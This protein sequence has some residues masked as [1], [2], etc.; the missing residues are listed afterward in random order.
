MKRLVLVI[1][2]LAVMLAGV[3]SFAA[4]ESHIINIRAHVESATYTTPDEINLGTVFPQEVITVGCWVDEGGQE[5]GRCAK[6]WLSSSFLRQ[7][8]VKDVEYEVW[9]EEKHPCGEGETECG[10][11]PEFQPI[12]PYMLLKDSD[13]MDGNDRVL[14][15]NCYP[16]DKWA[17]GQLIKGK[18]EVDWWDFR[19]YAPVCADNYNPETDPG[20]LPPEPIPPV[21]ERCYKGTDPDSYRWVDLGSDLKFQVTGFSY[22]T[23]REG[24]EEC[25][26]EDTE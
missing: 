9:C 1:V 22:C 8:R 23:C 18:D 6:I 4:F 7:S 21:I 24:E 14:Q 19:F 15:P 17:V 25:S 2:G 3:V 26:C 12:T 11:V 5:H 10:G 20:P 13:P 16:L